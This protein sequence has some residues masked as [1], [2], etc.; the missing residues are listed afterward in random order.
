MITE[1]DLLEQLAKDICG[2]D[3]LRDDDVTVSRLLARS[4]GKKYESVRFFLRKKVEAGELVVVECHNPENGRRVNA[5][6][7]AK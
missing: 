7:K 6:R 4:P 3:C 5:Y 2:M 1:N